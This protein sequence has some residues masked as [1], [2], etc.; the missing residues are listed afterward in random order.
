MV[1]PFK[2]WQ[3][4]GGKVNKGSRAIYVMAPV[5][6]IKKDS[7]GNPVRDPETGKPETYNT[8]R[9]V[10][11]FD[12]TQV[13]PREGK[14]LTLPQPVHGLP[15]QLKEED[16]KHIYLAL[17]DI[18]KNQNGVPIRFDDLPGRATGQY[19]IS[20]NEITIQKGMPYEQTLNTIIHEIAHSEL[21]NIDNMGVQFNG[22]LPLSSKELQAE[23]VAYVVSNHLGLDTSNHSF[24]YLASWSK[25]KD[26]LANLTAQLEVVQEKSRSLMERIDHTLESIQKQ[27]TN[28]FYERLENAKIVSKEKISSKQEEVTKKGEDQWKFGIFTAQG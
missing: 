24:G 28:P 14:E 21:H 8:F 22:V 19:S 26:G 10:P 11:V 4:R 1:A 9:P 17:K 2:E 16:Y 5:S 25:E 23:S 15:K 20:K 13:S 6:H 18:S 3:K 7:D 12:I 27:K